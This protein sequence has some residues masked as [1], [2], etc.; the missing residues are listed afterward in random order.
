[1]KPNY[2]QMTDAELRAYIKENRTDEEAIQE[3]FVH[4]RSP[5]EL[6]TWYSAPFSPE[7]IEETQELIRQKLQSAI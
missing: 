5:D 3:L 7:G 6:A 1:M 2:Q 4:R